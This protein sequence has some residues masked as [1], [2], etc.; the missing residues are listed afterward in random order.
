M[1]DPTL[2]AA[3]CELDLAEAELAVLKQELILQRL[4]DTGEPTEEARAA[5][6]RLHDTLAQLS[7][8]GS[9]DGE[10]AGEAA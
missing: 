10:I 8:G 9:P 1:L 7:A 4:V 6:A 2:E 5:L 3:R